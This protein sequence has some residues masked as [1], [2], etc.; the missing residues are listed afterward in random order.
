MA[1][2]SFQLEI[3][4]PRRVVFKGDVTSVS[5]PGTSGGFQVLHSHAPL[6]SSL[7]IGE[8]KVADPQGTEVLYAVSGGFAEVRENKVVVLAETAE[9]KDEIDAARASASRERAEKRMAEKKN[10]IDFERARF[11]LLRAINRLKVAGTP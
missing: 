2:K 4:T 7:K 8:L 11:S 9:R 5:A 3:I 10:E 1:D 6:L